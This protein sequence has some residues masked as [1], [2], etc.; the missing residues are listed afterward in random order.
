[1]TIRVAE[2]VGFS[3][4]SSHFL[5]RVPRTIHPETGSTG[6][7]LAPGARFKLYSGLIDA[8]RTRLGGEYEASVVPSPLA[9]A[10]LPG[11]AVRWALTYLEI[12][13][14]GDATGQDVITVLGP[15]GLASTFP[16]EVTDTPSI[17]TVELIATPDGHGVEV[18]DSVTPRNRSVLPSKDTEWS[19]AEATSAASHAGTGSGLRDNSNGP[20][21]KG[22]REK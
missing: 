6:V 7:V 21:L 18:G 20:A 22:S 11:L 16:L 14:T 12:W 9:T 10:E 19:L 17:D 4:V 2:P 15:R 5:I 8:S 1:V 13:L 3:F